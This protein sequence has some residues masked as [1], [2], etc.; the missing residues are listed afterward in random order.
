M[1][2]AAAP[3]AVHV[4]PVYD[5]STTARVD[6]LDFA[7]PHD[8]PVRAIPVVAA[9][10]TMPVTS[11]NHDAVPVPI[12]LVAMVRA[13]VV[14]WKVDALRAHVVG[15]V[16]AERDG[17]DAAACAGN[18]DTERNRYNPE[19]AAYHG[20]ISL[21]HTYVVIISYGSTPTGKVR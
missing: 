11:K 19:S 3:G 15:F 14:G 16:D 9:T 4:P 20:L 18:K 10:R 6:F 21:E 7:L 1:I 2:D 12:V 8:A 17:P 13:H 5:G